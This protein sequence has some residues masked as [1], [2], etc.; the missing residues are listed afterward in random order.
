VVSGAT[1]WSIALAVDLALGE[2]PASIHPVVGMGRAI[3]GL[4]RVAPADP[5]RARAFGVLLPLVPGTLAALA[6][7]FIGRLRPWPVRALAMAWALKTSFALRGL[8]GAGRRVERALL[9][10]DLAE[11]RRESLALVGRPTADL[12]GEETASAAIESLAENLCDSYVA[13]LLFYRIA[14]LP[15]ALAYRAANTADAMV[16]YRGRYEHLGKAAARL[17]DVLNLI[18]AR[19]SALA[20]VAA[21]TITRDS[22]GRAAARALREHART[23]S[24][25]AGWPMAA[26]A[27]ALGVRLCKRDHYSFSGER[28]PTPADIARARRLVA[29]AAALVTL[30]VLASFRRI[31][32]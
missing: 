1:A 31:G 9:A 7:V 30:F 20:L 21:A 18:P 11:A 12:S 14:G 19:V 3:A 23:A 6:G 16:G 17:D 27:G 32:P 5:R 8:L 2:P 13:P 22:P 10:G 4:E 24:P 26:A 25:N 29:G 28:A 15:G